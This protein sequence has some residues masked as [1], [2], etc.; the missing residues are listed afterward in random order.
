MTTPTT[1]DLTKALQQ[2][3]EL[4]SHY[5]WLLNF[6]DGGG[7][8]GFKTVEAWL[9]RLRM[10]GKLGGEPTG[11]VQKPG[12]CTACGCTDDQACQPPC[13]WVDPAHTLCSACAYRD[14]RANS[15]EILLAAVPPEGGNATRENLADLIRAAFDGGALEALMQE[16]KQF[17]KEFSK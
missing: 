11:P 1:E 8:I 16:R 17:G 4:Q 2:S 14:E 5:A 12:V 7:R 15:V 3:L 10:I 6:H 9:D 13:W